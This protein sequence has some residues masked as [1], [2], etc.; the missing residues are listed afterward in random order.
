[1]FT[2]FLPVGAWWWTSGVKTPVWTTKP[3]FAGSGSFSEAAGKPAKAGFVAQNGNSLP[4]SVSLFRDG[5][6][7]SLLPP[8]SP[9]PLPDSLVPGITCYV[10]TEERGEREFLT[11][12]TPPPGKP[13]LP[14]DG[15]RQGTGPLS[16]RD[17][18]FI[19]RGRGPCP[20]H[21]FS[22]FRGIEGTF[23][24]GTAK[25]SGAVEFLP[26]FRSRPCRRSTGD[27]RVG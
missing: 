11:P 2:V 10:P 12:V 14:S 1:M 9:A 15:N 3:V 4:V 21:A 23:R 18:I 8:S 17:E 26:P 5:G 20:T 13:H 16:A 27:K 25:L 7:V 19:G 22:L 24:V 6:W